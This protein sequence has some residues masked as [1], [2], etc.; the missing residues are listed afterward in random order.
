MLKGKDQ[1]GVLSVIQDFEHDPLRQATKALH[2]AIPTCCSG[3]E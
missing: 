3:N 2:A 1:D